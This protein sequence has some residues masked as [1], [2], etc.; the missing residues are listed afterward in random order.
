M[1]D[2]QTD[3]KEDPS[4]SPGQDEKGQNGWAEEPPPPPPEEEDNS[5]VNNII[6]DRSQLPKR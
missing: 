3:V 2:S 6:R 1:D 4:W 5:W